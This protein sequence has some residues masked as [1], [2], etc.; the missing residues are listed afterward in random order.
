MNLSYLNCDGVKGYI[1]SNKVVLYIPSKELK[2]IKSARFL[3]C[4]VH[5]R[6]IRSRKKGT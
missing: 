2:K 5:L 6:N 4:D 1:G 3:L